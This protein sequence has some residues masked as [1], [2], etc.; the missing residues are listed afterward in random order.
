MSIYVLSEAHLSYRGLLLAAC[1]VFL[2]ALTSAV[3]AEADGTQLVESERMGTR[4]TTSVRAVSQE[5]KGFYLVNKTNV[6]IDFEMSDKPNSGWKSFSLANGAALNQSKLRYIRVKT[7]QGKVTKT[8]TYDLH[9]EPKR[10]SLMWNKKHNCWDVW[11][12]QAPT[13]AQRQV[14]TTNQKQ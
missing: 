13:G 9:T 12:E 1:P 6:T 10:Y 3:A 11:R 8:R 5:A 14:V 2:L 4:E 7:V